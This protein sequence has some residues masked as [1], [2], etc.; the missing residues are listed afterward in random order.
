[1]LHVGYLVLNL[2]KRLLA[3]CLAATKAQAAARCRRGAE[4]GTQATH[5]KLVWCSDGHTNKAGV[6]VLYIQLKGGNAGHRWRCSK[7]QAPPSQVHMH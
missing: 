6:C 4:H 1:M 2:L 5:H 7:E 3:A